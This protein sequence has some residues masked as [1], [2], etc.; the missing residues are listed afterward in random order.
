[1]KY[2][3]FTIQEREQIQLRL[4]Q[5]ES[6]RAIA[7]KLDRSPSSISR[8]LKR[9]PPPK[10]HPYHPRLAHK[11]ALQARRSRGRKERLKNTQVRSYVIS[12]LKL[13]WSPQQI[14]GRIKIDLDYTISHEA[15]YQFIYAQIHRGGYGYLKLGG[16]DL[17]PYLRRRHK[18]RIR[19]GL[20]KSQRLPRF[21]GT[22]IEHRSL[23]V[24]ARSR[25]G[26]WESDTV[27]S[28]AGKPGVNTLLERTSGLYFITKLYDK[29]S[30]STK[31][32]I[33]SRLHNLRIH[34]LTF[35]NG[36]ENADW[37]SIENTLNT[38]TYFCHPYCSGERGSNENTNG[39]LR[40]FFPKRTDFTTIP[41]RELTT[42]EY[43][44]NTRPRKRLYW[45]T[46]LEVFNKSVALE[47]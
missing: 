33:V 10:R 34:T 39:L 38:K 31:Q 23:I 40:D 37:R 30:I 29:T 36:S 16:E 2:K 43:L 47:G 3:H 5:K 12:H 42:V 24:S 15:I 19:K 28:C 17:R 45:K 1:M 46:P 35:D 8:E 13:R 27:E 32:A 11:Q 9:H 21:N 18:R 6:L 44:L 41:C 20:R 26:D 22:S 25:I 14:A 4:W 7:T